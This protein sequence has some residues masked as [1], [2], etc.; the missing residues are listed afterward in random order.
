[1]EQTSVEYFQCHHSRDSLSS[2]RSPLRSASPP[3]DI[4]EDSDPF[5][6]PSPTAHHGSPKIEPVFDVISRASS[7]D[8]SPQHSD[9]EVSILLSDYHQSRIPSQHRSSLQHQPSSPYT[10]IKLQPSGFRNPSS[11]RALQDIT[12]P[13]HHLASPL[14]VGS[15]HQS[16]SYFPTPPRKGTPRS[17]Q[18]S[19]SK[20]SP[21]KRLAVKKDHPLILLHVTLLPIPTPCSNKTLEGVL[22]S[23]IL[24]N[25]KL[26]REKVTATVLDRGILIAHPREDYDLLEE[27]LLESL[28]LRMPRILACGHFH[29][30]A[31]E[32][33]EL[34]AASD[35]EL[36][37]EGNDVDIC[38]DCGRRVRDGHHGAG[39]GSR[40]WDIKLYAANGLMRAGAWGAAWGEMERVDVEICPWVSEELKR[41]LEIAKEAEEQNEALRR[42]LE[43]D[44]AHNLRLDDNT[45]AE[46]RPLFD[47]PDDA[48]LR[49]IYGDNA[50]PNMGGS[51][52]SHP[53][54][55]PIEGSSAPS[56]DQQTTPSKLPLSTLL[57]N[58]FAVLARDPRNVAIAILSLL[59][60]VLAI[61]SNTSARTVNT[62]PSSSEHISKTQP[63]NSY[64]TDA[65]MGI[66]SS[67]HSIIPS[68]S[69]T[70]SRN[71][72]AGETAASGPANS[73]QTE[74]YF[75]FEEDLEAKFDFD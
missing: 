72:P 12:P 7:P 73:D 52:S 44:T 31:D 43:E 53:R 71:V 2:V 51:E 29:L 28:E 69:S 37:E 39:A 65:F 24:S 10:P 42:T 21:S 57:I 25:W 47:G 32:E 9:D 22:P 33:A 15:R 61:T 56:A 34:L 14:S 16:G 3:R 75:R 36:Y 6:S 19:P 49:E 60:L 17:H 67:S 27:R 62:M 26:L 4:D 41:E 68:P 48:R 63:T 74:S 38:A 70:V 66:P 64:E 8:T 11:V 59:V 13:H 23:Y 5:S 1:M 40:R 30:D 20:I 46:D 45:Q 55:P 35:E 18:R 54:S 58:Y 50:P